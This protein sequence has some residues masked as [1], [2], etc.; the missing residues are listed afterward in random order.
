MPTKRQML[1]KEW[2]HKSTLHKNIKL[3]NN[4][5]EIKD[6]LKKN[7]KYIFFY[8]V[9][10]SNYMWLTGIEIDTSNHKMKK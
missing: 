1:S 6:K 4:R 2:R 9:K 10:N 8:L 7:K 5:N 3:N